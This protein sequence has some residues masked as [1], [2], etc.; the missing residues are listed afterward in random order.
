MENKGCITCQKCEQ[1]RSNF[2]CGRTRLSQKQ[3]YNKHGFC[4]DYEPKE[5]NEKQITNEEWLK[6]CNTEQLAEVLADVSLWIHP[7]MKQKNRFELLKK[8]FYEWLKQPHTR[9]S[10]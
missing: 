6:Q 5:Q 7:F 3:L 10:R 4:S 2:F 1:V 8:Q 9:S